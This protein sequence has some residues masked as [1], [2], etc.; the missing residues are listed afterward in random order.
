MAG[1]DS[2]FNCW[3]DKEDIA[4]NMS[5]YFPELKSSGGRVNIR[6]I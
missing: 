4:V 2:S 5:E 6:F 3:I 1:Y